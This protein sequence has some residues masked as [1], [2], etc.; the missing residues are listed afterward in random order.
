MLS[1]D[2]IGSRSF[3]EDKCEGAKSRNQSALNVDHI[4]NRPIFGA[5]MAESEGP[6]AI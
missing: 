1:A 2:K 5:S 3:Y 6:G 4:G